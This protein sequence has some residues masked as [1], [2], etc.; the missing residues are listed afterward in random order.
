MVL[1]TGYCDRPYVPDH[2]AGLAPSVQHVTPNGYRHRCALPPGG[3]LVVGAGA[4]GVQ[5]ADELAQAG[6]DVVLAVG[7]HSR[8]PRTYRGKD[9]W[10]WLER[11]G[12][13]DAT[14]E[15]VRDPQHARQEPSLQFCGRRDRGELN[16][17]VLQDAGVRLA[18]RLTGISGS[19]VHFADD[20]AET[21]AM[22]DAR[23]RRVL[24]RIDDTAA[25]GG[26]GSLLPDIEP[27]APAQ[28]SSGPRRLTL[29]AERLGTVVWATGY[30]R[31]YTWVG[32]PVVDGTGEIR[33]RRGV[34]PVPGLYAMGL[35]FQQRRSSSIID[36]ARH[37][38]PLLAD[39]IASRCLR[40]QIAV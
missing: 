22:A 27:P 38:A 39:H 28:V 4:T 36:G 30:R 5:I 6:R 24:A 31:S 26:P 17:G 14:L 13:L 19:T 25:S 37:D 23:M 15:Q 12:T 29:W 40:H 35:H 34:T 8:L 2:A 9:I 20:L 10:W 7:R 18:G 32:V 21:T 1:A 3:V 33:H 11:L 16:L